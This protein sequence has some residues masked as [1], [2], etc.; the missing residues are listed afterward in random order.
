MAI[1]PPGGGLGRDQK[2]GE[3]DEE[4]VHLFSYSFQTK[5][6]LAVA[7]AKPEMNTS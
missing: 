3:Q 1:F 5:Y 2:Q 6:F 4:A 7:P